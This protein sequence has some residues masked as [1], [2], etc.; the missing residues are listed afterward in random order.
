MASFV[1]E[2][3]ERVRAEGVDIHVPRRLQEPFH[4]TLGVVDG[5]AYPCVQA[6]DA[7]NKAIPPT[8]WT[9][10]GPIILDT[11]TWP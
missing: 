9:S 1:E 8:S 4:S 11:P 2:L 10:E 7:V 6:L 5:D 3:E